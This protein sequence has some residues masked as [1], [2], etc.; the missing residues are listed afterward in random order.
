MKN[1]LSSHNSYPKKKSF[2]TSFFLSFDK[3]SV[4]FRKEWKYFFRNLWFFI[5]YNY[6]YH[7]FRHIS[8][9]TFCDICIYHDHHS[10]YR[11]FS[12]VFKVSLRRTQDI[13]RDNPHYRSIRRI[14]DPHE[15]IY[16]SKK[17]E[18]PRTKTQLLTRVIHTLPP[19][20]LILYSCKSESS[21]SQMS[22][23]LLYLMHSRNH[24]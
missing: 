15:Q 2:Q 5:F 6:E 1:L 24:M 18:C 3:K 10:A 9:H 20:S 12:S 11:E 4:P 16:T 17:D 8:L 21:D 23:N 19:S 22:V 14:H 7:T 13:S